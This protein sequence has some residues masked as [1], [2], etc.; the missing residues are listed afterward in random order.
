MNRRHRAGARAHGIELKK[1]YGQHFLRDHS[2]ATEIVSSVP[3]EHASVLEVGPGDGFLSREILKHPIARLWSFEIDAAWV[4]YLTKIIQDARF[5]L[6][7]QDILTVDF[8]V[9]QEHAPWILLANLPYQITFPLLH[10]LQQ[11][12]HLFAEG[13]IMVQEEV[14]QKIVQKKGRGFG[15]TSLF[16]QYYFDWKLLHKVSP[17]SFEPP[18]KIYSRLLYFKPK[19]HVAPVYQEEQFWR[20]IKLCFQAPRRTLRN[21]LISAHY[22]LSAVPEEML[23][24]RAQQMDIDQLKHLWNILIHCTDD[25]AVGA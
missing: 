4:A 16:F 12:R 9:L 8:A 3:L 19:T 10:K 14:A 25:I 7:E 5:K 13:V 6:V 21:N 24:L 15:F 1:K 17:E 20:F 2:I 18:P 11:H 22:D 23:S